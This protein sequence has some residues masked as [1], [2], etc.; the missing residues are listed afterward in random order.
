MVAG[1]GLL[2]VV[3]TGVALWLWRSP[4]PPAQPPQRP[5]QRGASPFAYPGLIPSA[6]LGWLLLLDL[7]ATGHPRNRYLGLYQ[8]DYLFLALL[9][10]SLASVWRCA[11]GIALHPR[12]AA[13]QKRLRSPP[14]GGIAPGVRAGDHRVCR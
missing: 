10:V 2:V 7:S 4:W 6:G 12:P 9:I 1:V 11:L 13:T 14:G 3:G 8:H 5:P